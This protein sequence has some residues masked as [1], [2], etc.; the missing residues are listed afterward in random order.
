MNVETDGTELGTALHSG[1]KIIGIMVFSSDVAGTRYILKWNGK[2]LS[3]QAL[4]N[5]E[6]VDATGPQRAARSHTRMRNV[7]R[8]RKSRLG[9][10]TIRSNASQRPS[11][12]RNFL[13]DDR[14]WRF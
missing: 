3:S 14:R 7:T 9:H 5:P 2:S 13:Q 10:G 1:V 11:R 8:K 12:A 6:T 4:I